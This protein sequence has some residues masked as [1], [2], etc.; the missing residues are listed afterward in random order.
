M[1]LATRQPNGRIKFVPHCGQWRAWNSKKR[2]V[3]IIAGTQSGKTSFG[4]HWFYKE[5]QLCGP[6][7]YIVVTP[8]YPLLEKKALPELLK[9]FRQWLRLGEYNHQ[10]RCFT[11]SEDGC[12]RT[13]GC[14]DP[15]SPTK[16]WFGYA[17]DPE[18]LESMTAKAAWL[19]EAGQKKFKLESWQAIL[20]RLSLSMGR[21]LITT[22]PYDLG[23]LK[24]QLYDRWKRIGTGAE[25]PGDTD[26]DVIRFDSTENPL[27]PAEEFERARRDLPGWKFDLFYRGIFTRPA[28]LIYGSFID[29]YDRLPHPHTGPVTG[30]KCRPF[31]IPDDWPRYCGIDFGGVN[32]CAVKYAENPETRV[33]GRK[34][35]G[36]M[37]RYWEYLDGDKTSASHAKSILDGETSLFA[38]GG[39]K[40]EGQWR[41]EF[42]AA[43][44]LIRQPPISDV[45]VGISRVY[46]AYAQNRI[47][48][49]DTCVG[50]L[51]QVGSY[52]RVLDPLGE[53]TEEIE[54]KNTY[55]YMDA[56]RYIWA[57]LND[58]KQ[59]G[60]R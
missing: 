2:F 22:T 37:Y 20:R 39:A 24:Q 48:V 58:N 50:S 54:D 10:T 1:E 11:F 55:H 27:F 43:G 32:T 30:H 34:G 29:D 35:S 36:R 51:A 47:I 8:T 18:S 9:L 14:H 23:W 38:V 45:E 16:V 17:A 41:K 53:P 42:E 52:S 28:G 25:Q 7:D 6:G 3:C 44:L 33:D 21:V 4:P 31:K 57:Y 5:I 60:F 12:L 49:F 15:D 40:S 26:I 13:F 46:S 56:D 19:D 59:W